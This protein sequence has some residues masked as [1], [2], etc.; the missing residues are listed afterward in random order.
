LA[1][2]TIENPVIN[3]PFVEPTQHFATT[4]GQVTG[5]IEPRRRASAFFV[6]V[7]QPRKRSHQAIEPSP[8]PTRR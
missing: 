7:A 8:V 3:S 6:P 5:E 1:Q 2:G 4:D